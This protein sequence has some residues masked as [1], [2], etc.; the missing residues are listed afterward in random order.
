MDFISVHEAA[1]RWGVTDRRVQRL[2]ED[3]RIE[4]IARFGRSWMIPGDAEKPQDARRRETRQPA[5]RGD[6]LAQRWHVRDYEAIL[7]MRLTNMAFTRVNGILFIDIA[8]ELLDEC[9][10][11][12]KKKYPLS[13]ARIAWAFANGGWDDA[14]R[15]ALAEAKEIIESSC[16]SGTADGKNRR[17]MG[18]WTFAS[19]LTLY[20]DLPAMTRSLEDANELSGG[21]IDLID[22]SEPFPLN[23]AGILATFHTTPGALDSEMKT[24]S[25]FV[26]LY[27][28][29]TGGGGIGADMLFEVEGRYYRGDISGAKEQCRRVYD[30]AFAGGQDS[31]CIGAAHIL[32]EIAVLRADAELFN[33]AYDS[34]CAAASFHQENAAFC[35]KTL[36]LFRAGLSLHIGD[37]ASTPEWILK[38]DWRGISENIRNWMHFL[39]V[40]HNSLN[41]DINDPDSINQVLDLTAETLKEIKGGF[42]LFR[43]MIALFQS[44]LFLAAGRRREAYE[45]LA[46]AGEMLNRDEIYQLYGTM[47]YALLPIIDEYLSCLPKKAAAIAHRARRQYAKGRSIIHNAVFQRQ[48]GDSLTR[49][50]LEIAG[51]AAKGM[52]NKEIASELGIS[53]ETVRTHLAKV[54]Q[55]LLIDRRALIA[56]KLRKWQPIE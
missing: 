21:R 48:T 9:P 54:H 13:I 10:Y 38:D 53:S 24:M 15:L 41:L 29:M 3:G 46:G 12:I 51:L 8:R 1:R 52:R 19:V 31:I 39:R 4:R 43:S 32:A 27:S 33:N 50:E 22:A 17:L 34:M 47:Y 30:I 49:R 28:A 18:E 7:S 2:C 6:E 40:F 45:A 11:E 55:K 42:I 26:E 14:Y 25:R 20:P 37:N 23:C 35:E 16:P 56:E 36:D 5:N 44:A